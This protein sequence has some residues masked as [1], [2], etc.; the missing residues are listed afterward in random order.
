VKGRV[1][2]LDVRVGQLLKLVAQLVVVVLADLVILL[3]LLEQVHT[4]PPD[5]PH[6]HAGGIGI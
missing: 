6:R 3:Q 4:V 2:V 1:N 5:I